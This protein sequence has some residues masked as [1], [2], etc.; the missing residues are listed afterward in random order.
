[1]TVWVVGASHRTAPIGVRERLHVAEG[2]RDGFLGDLL[3]REQVREAVV[4]STCNRS[5]IYL[6]AGGESDVPRIA[7]EAFAEHAGV[8][9]DRV[10]PH[11]EARTGR[12]TAVH[13]FR[14]A[15]GLDSMVVGEPQIQ[16]Q[17]ARAY[18]A[19]RDSDEDA[20]GA[21]LHRLFQTALS[22]GGE[23][24]AATGISEGAASVP[25]AA[26][27]LARK[28][29]GDLGGRRAVVV[30]AGEMGRL[31]LTALL[32]RGVE[33][34][35]VAS[36]T[37]ERAEEAAEATGARAVAYGDVWALLDR[38]D[39]LV[40]STSA[41]HPV[42]TVDRMRELRRG[43]R[44]PVVVIDIAVPRDVEPEVEEI[45]DV[46]LYN[47][48]DLQRVVEATERSRG[49]ESTSAEELARARAG[50]FWRWYRAREAV[51]LIRGIRERAEAI[52]ERE[53][54]EALSE[55][56]GL[57]EE[58]R[59]RIHRA[60]RL[61]LKKILHAPT[62]GLRRLAVEEEDRQLLE[63]ANRLFDVEPEAPGG[64]TH[65]GGNDPLRRVDRPAEP[66]HE[67]ASDA[68]GRRSEDAGDRTDEPGG[69]PA[70]GSETA[71]HDREDP[72]MM[73]ARSGS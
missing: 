47:V 33:D 66:P 72:T 30:G 38:A 31:T 13:L 40:T 32:D 20:V 69:E 34:A 45:P 68:R 37:V 26:V 57:S 65:E 41:P 36:R 49:R 56:D 60:S 4:L 8:P 14:V 27:R 35:A 53:I 59:T 71:D 62:V 21:V 51:P 73:D 64:T 9:V 11:L 29:F 23:V 61:V 6:R 39:V 43:A 24:R 10:D 16:G 28:V 18:R 17:V 55:L 50:D 7:A 3:S 44:E 70:A 25:S 58:Q 5:E 46:F 2:E 19:A 42:V 63:L 54:S 1:M 48:D 12:A 22:A 67:G 52:R 15:A